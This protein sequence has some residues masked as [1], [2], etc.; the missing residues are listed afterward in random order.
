MQPGT[1]HWARLR[2]RV[3]NVLAEHIVATDV[4][5]HYDKVRLD[6]GLGP[7]PH[8]VANA[9][10]RAA[11]VYL[12]Q[13]IPSFELSS[14]Q[15]ATHGSFCRRLVPKMRCLLFPSFVLGGLA[16]SVTARICHTR[17]SCDKL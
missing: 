15:F 9:I 7:S 5:R 2:N 4:V 16:L 11:D 3:F 12:Q 8:Y 1:S 6:I 10:A 13:T 17:D 14:K